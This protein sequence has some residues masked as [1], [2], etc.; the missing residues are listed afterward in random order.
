MDGEELVAQGSFQICKSFQD[1][2]SLG[3]AV[4]LRRMLC[5]LEKDCTQLLLNL[6]WYQCWTS[7][8]YLPFFIARRVQRGVCMKSIS[9]HCPLHQ[10]VISAELSFTQP[11]FLSVPL[12]VCHRCLWSIWTKDWSKTKYFWFVVFLIHPPFILQ[13]Q[14]LC[15]ISTASKQLP[16]GWHNKPGKESASKE[17]LKVAQS[18]FI[19]SNTKYLPCFQD[20]EISLIPGCSNTPSGYSELC[21]R[22]VLLLQCQQLLFIISYNTGNQE[23]PTKLLSSR[24][25]VNKRKYF[26]HST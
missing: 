24:F 22:S 17:I 20:S 13:L 12:S 8:C 23:H 26:S 21:Q 25:E 3:N 16:Y 4:E 19:S 6:L 5:N 11:R 15:S 14:L 10:A 9:A 7:K 18:H 1:P 2:L